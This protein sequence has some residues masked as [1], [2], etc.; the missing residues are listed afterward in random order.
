MNFKQSKAIYRG[1]EVKIEEDVEEV[2]GEPGEDE[3]E[4]DRGEQINRSVA[5]SSVWK[6]I[7]VIK[8]EYQEIVINLEL[9]HFQCG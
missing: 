1:V 8:R 3:D 9:F 7:I 4:D 2:E 5:T 6:G